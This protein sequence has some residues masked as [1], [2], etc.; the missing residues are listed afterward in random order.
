LTTNEFYFTNIYV[1]AALI[2]NALEEIKGNFV[3]EDQNYTC[4]VDAER[5]KE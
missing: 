3:S 4:D 2:G 5:A 1:D